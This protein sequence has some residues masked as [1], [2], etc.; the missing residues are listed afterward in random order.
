MVAFECSCHIYVGVHGMLQLVQ[1][2]EFWGVMPALQAF[3]GV[4]IGF[5]NLNVLRSVPEL[6][7]WG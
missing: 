6:I 3:S 1:R 7:A 4:H 2:V 5:D